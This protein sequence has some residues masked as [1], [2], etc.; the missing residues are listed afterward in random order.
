MHQN[1]KE[2]KK[3]K[4]ATTEN[5]IFFE[6]GYEILG[7]C[8]KGFDQSIDVEVLVWRQGKP[9]TVRQVQV[10]Y[11]V[12]RQISAGQGFVLLQDASGVHR[13]YVKPFTDEVAL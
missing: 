1:T 12:F 2:V 13:I 11:L 10:S 3:M 4:K 5:Q 6:E 9:E 7:Y 8:R